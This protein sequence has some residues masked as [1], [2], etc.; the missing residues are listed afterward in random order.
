MKKRSGS[1]ENEESELLKELQVLREQAKKSALLEQEN[2]RLKKK[3]ENSEREI[4]K[5]K[6]MLFEA[7][8]QLGQW[9]KRFFGSTSER[10]VPSYA[11]QL[12]MD[13]E[14]TPPDTAETEPVKIEYLRKLPSTEDKSKPVRLHLPEHLKR[15][16]TEIYPEG[17]LS[18]MVYMGKQV[19]ERL[20]VTPQ[21]FKVIQEIRHKYMDVENGRKIITPTLPERALFKTIAGPGL[22][23]DMLVA[24]YV[25]SLP[26]TRQLSRFARMG[27]TIAKSTVNGWIKNTCEFLEPLYDLHIKAVLDSDY[28]QVDETPVR[29]LDQSK[30]AGIRKSYHWVYYSPPDRL[31]MFDFQ[32]GR[33]KTAPQKYLK[34]FKGTLQTDA[35]AVYNQFDTAGI[36]MAGCLAHSRRK[37]A[38]A[39]DNDPMARIPLSEFQQLYAIEHNAK[40]RRL[41]QD[42]LKEE[43]QKNALP[44]FTRLKLWMK[45]YQ[46][47]TTPSSPMGKAI[48]Y[49]MNNWKR[50]TAYLGNGK[51][52]IDNNPVERAIRVSAIGKR[53]FLFHGTHEGG[54]WAAM[55]YSFFGT[56]KLHQINPLE[57]L[58]DVL[59]RMPEYKKDKIQELLPQ[60]WAAAQIS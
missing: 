16:V 25:D 32:Q 20:E 39:Q 38:D 43:R 35:Y 24:K 10:F 6:Y 59:I 2:Q 8:Y 33:D 30:D 9:K 37:F 29:V 58:T 23:A 55:L 52:L 14:L 15:E 47:K 28:L 34:T 5:L 60:N 44:I 49:F 27:V 7:N 4:E 26:I 42:Q 18:G 1:A 41:D 17:D 46:L 3:L 31:V 54:Q 53:N 50:L 48:G 56:C 45:N 11:D 19:T 57:W 22:I 40:V 51:T 36:T 12:V 13:L 21:S